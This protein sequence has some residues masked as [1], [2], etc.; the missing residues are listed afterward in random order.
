MSRSSS[1]LAGGVDAVTLNSTWSRMQACCGN[2]MIVNL[3]SYVLSFCGS[4]LCIRGVLCHRASA[5]CPVVVES[6]ALSIFTAQDLRVREGR[7]LRH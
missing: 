5:G 7:Q 1:L 6:E 4:E 2:S 3:V